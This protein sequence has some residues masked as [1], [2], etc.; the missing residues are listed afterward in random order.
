MIAQAGLPSIKKRNDAK[1][2]RMVSCPKII[3]D[4]QV[5]KCLKCNKEYKSINGF[6]MCIRCRPKK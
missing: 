5:K 4:I 2:R 6:R 3:F 1:Y